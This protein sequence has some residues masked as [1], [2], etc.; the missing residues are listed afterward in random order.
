MLKINGPINEPCGT[1]F[2][3]PSQ[4]LYLS[5]IKRDILA[6]LTKTWSYAR[7]AMNCQIKISVFQ[8]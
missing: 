1:P 3:K 8:P 6:V 4:S 2:D 5:Y 7:T